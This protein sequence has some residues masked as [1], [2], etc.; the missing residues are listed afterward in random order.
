MTIPTERLGE[1]VFRIA[2]NKLIVSNGRV[3]M[4]ELESLRI[5]DNHYFPKVISITEGETSTGWFGK[6]SSVTRGYSVL[7]RKITE[8]I[9]SNGASIHVRHEV[10]YN[11]DA[12]VEYHEL[13]GTVRRQ[14]VNIV[15]NKDTILTYQDYGS[16]T[17]RISLENG[18][19]RPNFF[20]DN[21]GNKIFDNRQYRRKNETYIADFSI[22]TK[23]MLT[24]K[25][26]RDGREAVFNITNHA[27]SQSPETLEAVMFGAS[28]VNDPN[29]GV[30]G[31]VPRGIKT[32]WSAF[33]VSTEEKGRGITDPDFLEALKKIHEAGHEVMPHRT[34]PMDDDYRVN[35]K[36]RLEDYHKHFNS[37]MWID[38]SLGGGARNIGLKSEGGLPEAENYI[39]DYLEEYGYEYAWAY[40]DVNRYLMKN[41]IDH[42][43]DRKQGMP[44][45]L[46]YQNT[47]LS[48][49]NSVAYQ[50]PTWRA[51]IQELF[52]YLNEK[53]IDQL[54]ENQG[55]SLCHEYF[56]HFNQDGYMFHSGDVYRISDRL[57]KLLAY[58]S[59]KQEEGSLWI[60]T[61]EEFGDRFQELR[62]VSV[63]PVADGYRVVNDNSIPVKGFT[64]C[65][66]NEVGG[67]E[68]NG[69]SINCKQTKKGIIGW[70][71]LPVG[72]SLISLV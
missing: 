58:L 66:E 3:T 14:G 64:V 23:S 27:D 69:D 6:G 4:M 28:D 56:A 60:P 8:T 5:D 12:K 57:D 26:T 45:F 43:D 10:T 70:V 72:E 68:L 1:I 25:P 47:N 51:P 67:L 30:K 39:M 49:P 11:E 48:F 7:G 46:M 65:L 2:D 31:F 35:I 38:H 53:T 40:I 17:V 61:L 29:Y 22:T 63:Y 9:S 21:R 42:L 19:E 62:K 71:D 37:R 24:I 52:D 18:T 16:G 36:P 32:S 59:K 54:I 55:V 15:G 41:Y 20:F 44:H 34:T 13:V 50:Y 33:W